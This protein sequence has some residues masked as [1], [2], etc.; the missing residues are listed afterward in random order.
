MFNSPLPGFYTRGPVEPMRF[1]RAVFVPLERKDTPMLV[2]THTC[3]QLRPEHAGQT[4]T[5]NG[6]VNAY[7]DHGTG[8]IFVDLRDRHGLTQIVFDKEDADHHD[9]LDRADKLRV[10]DIVAV[11]GAVRLRDGGPNPKLETGEVEVVVQELSVLSKAEDLP[12]QPGDAQ[13]LPGEELRLQ[14]RYLDLRRPAMQRVL[15][16]RHRIAK[17]TRDFFDDND[18]LEIETPILC[19]ATP[20]GAR[21]FLVPSRVQ[22]GRW[23]AL[24]Q[25]PQLFKQILMVSG[26]DRYIQ[27]ARCFRD[28][29]LRADRQ[30]EFTQVDLEMSF[31]ERETV[32]QTMEAYAK[33]LWKRVAGVES[34]VFPR[35]TY[36][37]SMD[38]FGIDRPDLRYGLELVDVSDIVKDSDFKVFAGALA[39]HRGVVKAI[40][41]PGGA[42]K[43]TRKITDGY[44][45]FVK[46][47]G[48]GGVP[49]AKFL[50]GKFDTG[51]AK[52]IEAVGDRLAERLGV[53]DG[54]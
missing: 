30:P 12:F 22:P 11:K 20:E 5:L 31:V 47:F 39:K 33:A 9:L 35:L 3:G 1:A 26:Y 4:V 42:E 24:P 23:Y 32:L 36:R 40:R 29:D 38:R 18:F 2:R 43:F 46:Q 28:E 14:H 17:F 13:N 27:I 19:K 8:L 25:S 52:F 16:L 45:E 48:A 44:T 21:D 10:E 53:E 54:D 37:E 7:R 41:V 50:G 34:E 51:I 6:W 15:A 49:T